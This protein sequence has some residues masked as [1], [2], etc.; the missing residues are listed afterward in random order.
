MSR[1]VTCRVRRAVAPT[2]A[3]DRPEFPRKRGGA[4]FIGGDNQT[5]VVAGKSADDEGMSQ[6][7]EGASDRGRRAELRLQDDDVLRGC[8]TTAELRQH[9]RQRLT[10]IAPPPVLGK[11]VARATELV[12]TLLEP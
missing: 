11:D 1:R 7:V 6:P 2:S 10:G 4:R 8:R 3:N 5:A 12:V 9:R